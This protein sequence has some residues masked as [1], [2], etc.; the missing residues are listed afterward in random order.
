MAMKSERLPDC[1][2]SLNIDHGVSPAIDLRLLRGPY[3]RSHAE[4]VGHYQRRH[5]F[6]RA[7]RRGHWDGE[8][9]VAVDQREL[10][11]QQL[12]K[13]HVIGIQLA[14][15]GDRVLEIPPARVRHAAKQDMVGRKIEVHGRDLRGFACDT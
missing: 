13:I 1:P 7:D 12:G 8:P 11:H 2:E 9:V 14:E 10:H 5:A 15:I 4:R 6:Q 3:Q